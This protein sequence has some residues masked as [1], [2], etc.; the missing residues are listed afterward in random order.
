MH[1]PLC[2]CGLDCRLRSFSS[3]CS[4]LSESSPPGRRTRLG[5]CH[6]SHL[7]IPE[8]GQHCLLQ[9]PGCGDWLISESLNSDL[10]ESNSA[11]R[12]GHSLVAWV[13]LAQVVPP[14]QRPGATPGNSPRAQ[15]NRY[16]I[17][18]RVLLWADSAA[19]LGPARIR[20]NVNAASLHCA[21]TAALRGTA[22]WA[23]GWEG[24]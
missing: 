12:N 14:R 17:N 4:S 23:V 3:T 8:S 22:C 16:E 11:G 1:S 9:S 20:I 7:W 5:Q 6:L 18:C 24:S 10:T 15:N 19:G 21:A 13:T 2:W